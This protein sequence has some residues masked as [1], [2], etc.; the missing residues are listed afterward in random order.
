MKIPLKAKES[1]DAQRSGRPESAVAPNVAPKPTEQERDTPAP[2]PGGAAPGRDISPEI[3]EAARRKRRAAGPNLRIVSL[4][5]TV[6]SLA[7]TRARI[8]SVAK[9]LG[10][11]ATFAPSST[12]LNVEIA[13]P[14]DAKLEACLKRI[15]QLGTVSKEL[16]AEQPTVQPG[17]PPQAPATPQSAPPNAASGGLIRI[18]VKEAKS[19]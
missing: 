9:S 5:V 12:A 1:S 3:G 10:L 7:E 13:A 19:Q 11:R 2:P 14:T 16:R 8:A 4:A 15:R 6:N 18:E 17:R